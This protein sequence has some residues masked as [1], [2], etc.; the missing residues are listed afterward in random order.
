[1]KRKKKNGWRVVVGMLTLGIGATVARGDYPGVA[2]T[3]G[4]V[5]RFDTAEGTG[6]VV[7]RAYATQEA[8]GGNTL[9]FAYFGNRSEFL[10]QQVFAAS[11]WAPGARTITGM[12]L[13]ADTTY[14]YDP[15][16]DYQATDLQFTLSTTSRGPDQLYGGSWPTGYAQNH[17]ADAVVVYRGPVHLTHV[18]GSSSIPQAFDL[19]IPFTRSFVFDPALGNLLIE[20]RGMPDNQSTLQGL[21]FFDATNQLG[22]GTSRAFYDGTLVPEPGALLLLGSGL[23]WAGG[24]GLAAWGRPLRRS[25]SR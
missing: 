11:E 6:A 17:G 18:G 21:I 24:L 19:V 4:L 8:P 16:F 10:Y 13:R 20:V 7:P 5:I 22:D 1:M 9:P 3:T 14:G 25:G 15:G 2:D 12:A 23:L